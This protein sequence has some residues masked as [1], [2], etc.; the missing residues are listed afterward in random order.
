MSAPFRALVKWS[1]LLLINKKKSFLQF[2]LKEGMELLSH[3]NGILSLSNDR[4]FARM[5][6]KKTFPFLN[7]PIFVLPR[8][9]LVLNIIF[10]KGGCL[11]AFKKT[12]LKKP[13]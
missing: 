6:F 12:H 7:F 9:T 3:V 4:R 10:F 2:I 8:V 13:T 1:S 11:E 5:F